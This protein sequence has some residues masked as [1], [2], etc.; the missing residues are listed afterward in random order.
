MQVALLAPPHHPVPHI[1]MQAA[2]ILRQ[3]S[4]TD[5]QVRDM[6]MPYEEKLANIG[7]CKTP[8]G[9]MVAMILRELSGRQWFARL[10]ARNASK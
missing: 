10:K 5:G 6:L 9:Q 7:A 8:H 1:C 3:L 4:T 2:N